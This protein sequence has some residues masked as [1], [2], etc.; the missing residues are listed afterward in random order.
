MGFSPAM[1]YAALALMALFVAGLVWRGFGIYQ[2]DQRAQRAAD[3]AEA[4]KAAPEAQGASGVLEAP[5]QGGAT[6]LPGAAAQ[7]APAPVKKQLVVHVDG[8]VNQPGVYTFEEGARVHEAIA[9][10]GGAL[11]DG[12]PGAL[13]LAAPLTD[14]AK[15]YVYKRAELQPAAPAPQAAQ[16]PPEARAATYSPVKST[17]VAASSPAASKQPP[18]ANLNTATAAELE[19]VPGIGPATARA[20]LEYRSKHGPF[21]RVDDLTAVSGIGPKTLEKLRPYLTV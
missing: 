16:P 12:V 20:I 13:N 1:R 10:A 14:G 11:P 8:A 17:E 3:V 6:G 15:V 5:G 18:V 19:A 21:K 2:E 4:E 9:A 7:P